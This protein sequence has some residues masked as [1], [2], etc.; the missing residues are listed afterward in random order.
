MAPCSRSPEELPNIVGAHT[1]AK[2]FNGVE[3][4]G[5]SAVPTIRF[6]SGK[7]P[8]ANAGALL[9]RAVLR[10]PH[11]IFSAP[12]AALKR[13]LLLSTYGT[14]LLIDG[15]C[16]CQPREI[17]A[18][19][20]SSSD[21]IMDSP[22]CGHTMCVGSSPRGKVDMLSFHSC[23]IIIIASL[24]LNSIKKTGNTFLGQMEKEKGVETGFLNIQ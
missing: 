20:I 13:D 5:D 19:N 11:G 16:L 2:F 22:H 8:H 23:K 6:V 9:R 7:G 24:H 10:P 12:P 1:R 15:L 4:S 21:C 17:C 3:T 14:A 18:S